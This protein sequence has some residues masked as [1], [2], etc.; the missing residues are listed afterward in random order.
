MKVL[1]TGGT[2]FLGSHTV[3]RLLAAGHEPRLLTRAPDKVAP[4][5]EKMHIDVTALDVV[6]GDITDEASVHRAVK[7]CEAVVHAAA[8]VAMD[9]TLEATME[10][11]NLAGTTNV[12]GAAVASGC[13]P[14]IHVSSAAALFPFQT[15]P[16]TADHPVMG[17]GT[18]Y[19][20]TKAACDLLAR[21]YQDEGSPVV[22]LYPSGIMGPDDWNESINLASYVLWLEKGFP[23][24]KGYSGSYVDVR[25]LA[26][27]IVA[28]MVAGNGPRRYLAFGTYFTAQSLIAT[29]EEAIG[30]KVKSVPLPKPVW[31]VWGRAGDLARRFGKD[32]VLTSDGFD[33]IFKSRRG[34]DS[35]TVEATGV[36]FRPAAETFADTFRWMHQAGHVGAEKVGVLADG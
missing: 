22:I 36:E 15:D 3:R 9:P 25:D 29:M 33:F 1:I 14:I 4:L 26:E 16:V 31:W 6:K 24:S 2:G 23:R 30:A 13:D 28:A 19:G 8:V 35:A 10:S 11:T 18:A 20:R 12:L 5:M 27:I 32:L 17:G 7:G 21:R 34:D